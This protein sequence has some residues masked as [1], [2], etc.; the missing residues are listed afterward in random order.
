MGQKHAIIGGYTQAESNRIYGGSISMRISDRGIQASCITG[1]FIDNPKGL[2]IYFENGANQ[3]F[4]QGNTI[5]KSSGNP[6]RVDYGEGNMLRANLLAGNKPQDVILLHEGGNRALAAPSVTSATPDEFLRQD[7][8]L[9]AR[10]DVSLRRG[11]DPSARFYGCRRKR[12]IYL[13]ISRSRRREKRFILLVTDAFGNTSSFSTVFA[14]P[15][16]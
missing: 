4:V 5:A 9:R 3:N 8:S 15:V 12:R 10:G 11:R 1:N 2:A 7:G 16:N 13:R 14:L 6:L